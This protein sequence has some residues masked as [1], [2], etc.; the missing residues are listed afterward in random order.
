M[1]VRQQQVAKPVR[2]GGAGRRRSVSASYAAKNFGALVDT[3]R[4][5]RAAY[6]VERAGV[7]VVELM[8]ARRVRATLAGLA[9][10]FR[11]PDRLPEEYL[12]EVERGVARFNRPTLPGEPWAS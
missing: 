11:G 7:P 8:P 1:A 4:E 5:E 3:V 9:A 6:I 2:Q 10:V 12:R